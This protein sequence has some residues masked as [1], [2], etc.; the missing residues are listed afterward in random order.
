MIM[1]RI[2]DLVLA[3]KT[4]AARNN[5]PQQLAPALEALGGAIDELEERVAK[6]EK[7]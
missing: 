3:M 6:L 4:G 7:R 5:L 2:R 1:N